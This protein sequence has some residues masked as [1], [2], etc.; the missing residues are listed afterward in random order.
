[1]RELEN[2]IQRA[3]LMAKDKMITDQDLLF[4]RRAGGQ[5]SE[6]PL[7][8]DLQFKIG[9]QPLKTILAEFEAEAI[10]QALLKH[11]G[12]VAL[13]ADDLKVGKTALYDKMKRHGISAK[14]IKKS[15]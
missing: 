2:I 4:D 5:T 12:N 8:S 11:K 10:R 6:K 15:M 13:A 7:V 3:V 9:V 1:V 14:E